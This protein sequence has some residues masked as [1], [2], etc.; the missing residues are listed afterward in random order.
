MMKA[1]QYVSLSHAAAAHGAGDQH[2]H[3]VSPHVFSRKLWP[4]R[5]ARAVGLRDYF[6]APTHLNPWWRGEAGVRRSVRECVVY[7]YSI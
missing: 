1:V 3:A 2:A 6:L 5:P 7:W 4:R